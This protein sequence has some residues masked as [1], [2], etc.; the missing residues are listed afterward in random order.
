[1]REREAVA[2]KHAKQL[3]RAMT[4]AEALLWSYVRRRSLAGAKFPRQHPI[5]PYIADFACVAAKLVVEI[6]GA[7][8]W[9]AEELAHDAR[10]TQFLEASGWRVLRVTNNDVYENLDGV[11]LTIESRIPPPAATP[12]PPP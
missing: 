2:R 11:W 1:M 4:R 6:D 3:R 7:T 8:H 5:G 10:R 12:P 9:T